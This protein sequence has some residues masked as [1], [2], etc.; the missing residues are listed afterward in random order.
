MFN[1]AS[2]RHKKEK[3]KEKQELQIT[4]SCYT[5]IW[6]GLQQLLHRHEIS[7]QIM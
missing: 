3:Q 5:N 2:K 1:S 6:K 4:I 7:C